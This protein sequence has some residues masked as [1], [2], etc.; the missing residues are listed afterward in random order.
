[1]IR[2]P[3]MNDAGYSMIGL[4]YDN[5]RQAGVHI[6]VAEAFIPNPENKPTVNHKNLVR[7]DNRVENLEWATMSEQ[8][9]HKRK[10]EK[11]ASTARPVW[12]CDKDTGERIKRYD[13]RMAAA[14]DLGLT[15]PEVSSVANR[16]TIA[17][18][19]FFMLRGVKRDFKQAYGF[20]WKLADDDLE[21]EIWKDVDAALLRGMEGYLA[22]NM[23]RI[24]TPRGRITYGLK[25]AN[26]YML[27][28]VRN[29][30]AASCSSGDEDA[31]DGDVPDED[32]PDEYVPDEDAP[33]ESGDDWSRRR[34]GV[35]RVIATTFIPNPLGKPVVNHDDGNRENNAVSNLRWMTHKENSQHAYDTGLN[36]CSRAVE[37]LTLDGD[38]V[39]EFRSLADA[40]RATGVKDYFICNAIKYDK[41]AGGFRWKYIDGAHLVKPGDCEIVVHPPRPP[42]EPI[43]P[44]EQLS[45][46]GTVI[47]EFRTAEEAQL[48]TGHTGLAAA[49]RD[50]IPC[51]GFYWRRKPET[52]EAAPVM[53]PSR[54]NRAIQQLTLEGVVIKGFNSIKEASDETGVNADTISRGLATMRPAGKFLWRYTPTQGDEMARMVA[55]P[56][57]QVAPVRQLTVDGVFIA[58]HESIAQAVKA[59]GVAQ[60]NISYGLKVGRPVCGFLWERGDKRAGP[61]PIKKTKP[62]PKP[63]QQLSLQ[64]DF[65]ARFDTV[66]L[67]SEATGVCGDNI[68]G[69]VKSGN[70][71]GGFIWKVAEA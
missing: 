21:G 38:H 24:R 43:V 7:H 16:I 42:A 29:P 9:Q 18:R 50:K 26:G 57:D 25:A 60:A 13:S 10:P 1:M 52:P 19:G 53:L 70:A 2:K 51:K 66:K 23:G 39:G 54:K 4:A 64:G 55:A 65:I 14:Q 34:Y 32:V 11:R 30:A 33:D 58:D 36:T 17:M 41:P 44:V 45:L 37:Q 28:D 12:K 5:K 63:V 49:I 59:T 27:V 8:N 71:R 22:S 56:N 20:C 15:S 6:Y 46:D 31:P 62:P 40:Y 68:R 61:R 48:K 47:A 3:T 69:G 67:A 35:H